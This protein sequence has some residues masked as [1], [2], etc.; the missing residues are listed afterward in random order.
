MPELFRGDFAAAAS[1]VAEVRALADVTGGE[2]AMAPY[3]D[4][5]LAAL[6]GH[7]DTAVPVIRQCLA[8]V[9][10]RG[11]GVGINMA[12]WAL[13]VLYNG[14]GRYGDALQAAQASA[15]EWIQ[16]GPP[17]WALAE[18]VEAAVYARNL[19]AARAAVER[20]AE[21]TQASGT[22]WALGLEASR[23]AL[24]ADGGA[25][26]ALHQEAVERLS[27]TTM[28]LELARAQLLYGEFLRRGARRIDARA[29]L[30]AAHEAFSRMGADAFT[31]RA[32][33]ELLATGE[34]ARKRTIDTTEQL[35]PQE[36]AIADLAAAGQTNAEIGAALYISARTVE[37]HL[38]K[39][40]GK[41]HV[42]TRKELRATRRATSLA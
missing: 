8:D 12:Q 4:L 40:Y 23:R 41:L 10:A 5:C 16:P 2:A 32:G 9:T 31:A 26:A 14:L 11:E 39:V 25:A 6:R 30:R 21:M 37:W 18:L 1:L 15:Q 28:Q 19:P 29:Q 17:K 3:G 42:T 34:T 7:E 13:A 27:A 38:R 35:T 22:E 24:L 20:L 36:A 33:R